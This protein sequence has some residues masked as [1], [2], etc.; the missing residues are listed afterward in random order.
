MQSRVN[1]SASNPNLHSIYTRVVAVHL[2]QSAGTFPNYNTTTCRQPLVSTAI[3]WKLA[4]AVSALSVA[5][6]RYAIYINSEP[7]T[8]VLSLACSQERS[9]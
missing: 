2:Q 9:R 5:R 1:C 4:I 3:K 7:E 6:P 8:A